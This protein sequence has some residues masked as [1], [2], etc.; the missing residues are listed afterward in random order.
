[1]VWSQ[2]VPTQQLVSSIY[3]SVGTQDFRV[4]CLLKVMDMAQFFKNGNIGTSLVV[5]WLKLHISTAGGTGLI[6]G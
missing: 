5:Q 2:F 4:S 6:P 1:M 3:R